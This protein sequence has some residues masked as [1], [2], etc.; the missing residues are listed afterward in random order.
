MKK[1]NKGRITKWSSMKE[2]Y[3]AHNSSKEMKNWLFFMKRSKFRKVLLK[4]V[5][6]TIKR[7]WMIFSISESQLQ[8]LRGNSLYLR[9]RQHVF[10]ILR[11]KSI[12]YKKNTL[13]NSRRPN[14]FLMSWKSLSMFTDGENWNAQILKPMKW[15][16]KSNLCKRGLLQKQKKC[17]RKMFLFKKKRN[18]TSSWKIFWRN[19]AGQKWL[20]S[21]KFINK[22]WKRELSNWKKWWKS[23][24]AT[25]LK[26]MLTTL[27]LKDLESKSIQSKN[28][29]LTQ[30]R[31]KSF[32]KIW[33]E[34]RWMIKWIHSLPCSSSNSKCKCSN[35]FRQIWICNNRH[36]VQQ[37]LWE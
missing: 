10:Q 37:I 2:I 5:K 36:R 12:S 4:K 17:L 21:F 18:Y 26:W 16:K 1:P 32:T 35:R 34:S 25:N 27:R 13:S 7:K 33:K 20:R 6:S 28:F 24:R 11:E 3:F 9:M 14:I 31:T 22:T 30:S 15:F 23:L 29:T 19:R 8:T